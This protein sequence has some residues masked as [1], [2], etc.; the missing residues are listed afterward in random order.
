MK[1]LTLQEKVSLTGNTSPEIPRLGVPK[2][3]W[4][5]EGLHGVAQGNPGI[6]FAEPGEEFGHATSF[7]MPILM[8]AA[9]D[10]EM[11]KEV[12]EVIAIEAR[13]FNNAN[14]GG[15]D[16]WTP[17]VNPFRDVSAGCPLSG[18]RD[19]DWMGSARTTCQFRC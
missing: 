19:R 13:A 2:Y 18:V 12:A 17:N 8:A 7:P 10:D 15:L 9:F 1:L 5:S 14:R 11:I 3:E 6:T 4:W 16:Y